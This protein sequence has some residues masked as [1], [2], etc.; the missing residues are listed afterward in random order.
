MHTTGM[1][2]RALARDRLI[3][4]VSLAVLVALCWLYLWHGAGTGMSVVA[5]STWQFPPPV[6]S[7]FM[8]ADWSVGY[9]ILM[10]AMWW[11][12]MIAMMVPSAAPMILLY[13]RVVGRA[14]SRGQSLATLGGTGIFLFGYL[15]IWLV[16]SVVATLGQYFL[17]ISGL[18]DGMRMWSTSHTA[19]AVILVAAGLYQLTPVKAACLD[20]CRAPIA[21]LSQHFRPGNFGA[22]RMGLEHGAYCVGCCWVLM[23]LLYVG[24]TMNL[25]WI[26][27][28]TL[29]VLVEKLLA[30]GRWLE[31]GTGG[32]LIAVGV[33]LY[34][35][36]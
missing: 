34:L 9:L 2:E 27:G 26:V 36:G 17:E 32:V 19:S 25:V 14:A 1:I 10:L 22:W 29:L 6:P 31:R 28:L 15:T 12:M 18:L 33:G 8:A 23:A 16:F 24:G 21:F 4:I 30:R 3:V 7:V 20:H 11:V 5:M 13:S 35:A